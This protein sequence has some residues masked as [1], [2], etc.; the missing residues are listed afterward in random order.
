MSR[1]APSSARLGPADVARVIAEPGRNRELRALDERRRSYDGR[2]TPTFRRCHRREMPLRSQ[3]SWKDGGNQ[4]APSENPRER[5]KNK[6]TNGR[7][8]N[9][10]TPGR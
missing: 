6:G 1:W 10:G 2:K 9:G 4:Q 5:R 3:G 7:T 8:E